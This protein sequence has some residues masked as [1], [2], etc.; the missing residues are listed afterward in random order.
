MF[1]TNTEAT[2]LS[3]TSYTGYDQTAGQQFYSS[4]NNAV[5]D[6]VQQ[7]FTWLSQDIR[8]KAKMSSSQTINNAVYSPFTALTNLAIVAGDT[9]SGISL[10]ASY[11][12]G[13]SRLASGLEIDTGY[14]G[15]YLC[16]YMVE[17]PSNATGARTAAVRVFRPGTGLLSDQFGKFEVLS[18]GAS[19]STS[20]SPATVLFLNDLDF[21]FIETAQSSGGGLAVQT[22]SYLQL[23]RLR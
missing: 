18:A 23:V 2:N 3:N 9:T 5:I 14:S 15:V 22:S 17:Y 11:D 8:A 10:E 4:R 1:P 19:N 7:V 6:G 21:V 12:L 13:S 20:N 16:T